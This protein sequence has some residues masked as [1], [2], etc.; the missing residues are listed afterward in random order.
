MENIIYSFEFSG[1]KEK[2][3]YWYTISISIIIWLI[4]WWFITKIYWLSFLLI[5]FS[6][7]Y[8]F[9]ENNS[10]DIIRVSINDNWISIWNWFYDFASIKSFTVIYEKSKPVILRL[11]LKKKWLRFL[12][13][14]INEEILTELKEVLLKF[15]EENWEKE[16]SFSEKVIRLLKL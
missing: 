8:Y 6:W 13:L 4:I 9:V 16:L 15:L 12:D 14:D 5:L 11:N 2:S 10:Q 3:V 7:V 1:K